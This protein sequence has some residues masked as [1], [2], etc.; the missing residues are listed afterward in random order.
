[1]KQENKAKHDKEEKKTEKDT[2]TE[3]AQQDAVNEDYIT[4]EQPPEQ[5]Q[6]TDKAAEYLAM[7]QRLQADF[8]NYRKRTAAVRADAML[9]G[10]VE[11]LKGLLP[12]VDNLG[13]ALEH[14][15]KDGAKGGLYEGLTL[16]YKQMQELLC[17]LC[18]EEI[19]ALGQPFDPNLHNAV[20]QAPAEEGQKANEVTEVFQKGYKI[21]ERVIRYAMVKVAC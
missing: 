1:M 18:V 16:V 21:N 14:E 13:R 2:Q 7:A 6:A 3:A 12:I 19:S 4:E 8:D 9:D 15:E 11:V 5:K 20:M 10:K 17:Q